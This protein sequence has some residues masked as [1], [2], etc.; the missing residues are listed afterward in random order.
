MQ[1]RPFGSLGQVSALTLGGGGIGSVWG[2]VERAEAVA[3]VRAA[4]DAGITMLDVAPGYGSGE[5]VIE[6]RMARRKSLSSAV[7]AMLTS[8]PARN[9]GSSSRRHWA[10]RTGLPGQVFPTTGVQQDG[11]PSLEW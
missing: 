9:A 10:T 4:L 1:M 8:S 5:A 11:A 2:T 3:T 7:N 6:S